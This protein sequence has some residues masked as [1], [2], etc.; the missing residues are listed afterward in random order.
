MITSENDMEKSADTLRDEIRSLRAEKNMLEREVKRLRA[1]SL[2]T[3]KLRKMMLV[4]EKEEEVVAE[5]SSQV[6]IGDYLLDARRWVG[7]LQRY[8]QYIQNALG[9]RKVIDLNAR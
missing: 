4:L 7:V 2:F 1:P 9:G 5:L 6:D 8:E 3:A